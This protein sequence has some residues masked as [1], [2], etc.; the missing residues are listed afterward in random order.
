MR[1]FLG[2]ADTPRSQRPEQEKHIDLELYQ[3]NEVQD[4]IDKP[5]AVK[6]ILSKNELGSLPYIKEYSISSRKKVEHFLFNTK[7]VCPPQI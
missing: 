2:N 7:C 4:T 1:R 5:I 3:D 6:E